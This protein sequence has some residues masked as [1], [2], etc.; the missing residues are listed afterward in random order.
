MLA[1]SRFLL[2]DEAFDGSGGLALSRRNL[3]WALAV[4]YVELLFCYAPLRSLTGSS[5]R[6][7]PARG[8]A[9]PAERFEPVLRRARAQSAGATVFLLRTACAT[10]PSPRG[11]PSGQER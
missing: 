8:I 11:S 5:Q 6:D 7:P 1:V 3:C 9:A 2:L 4:V 10:R